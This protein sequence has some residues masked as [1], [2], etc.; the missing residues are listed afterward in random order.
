MPKVAETQLDKATL[1]TSLPQL[2]VRQRLTSEQAEARATTERSHPPDL[3]LGKG[4]LFLLAADDG[5][6]A[7]SAWP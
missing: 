4:A 1:K 2:L 7:Q 5:I 6:K 3:L